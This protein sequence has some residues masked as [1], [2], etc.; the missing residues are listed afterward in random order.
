MHLLL[1]RHGQSTGNAARRIQ[2]WNDEPLTEVG[3]AQALALTRRL[4][5]EQQIDAIY[6][7]P[8]LR[9]CQTAE[10]IADI[11]D[12]AVALDERLKEHHIGVITGLRFE[13]VESQ[14]P[15]I[16]E[17]WQRD[18]W[19]VPIP[20]MEDTDVFQRRVVSAMDE[21]VARHKGDDTI[22]VIAHGG[23]LGAY[24]ASLLALDLRKRQPW[25]FDNA[26]L[27]IV[28]LGGVRPRIALLNDTCHLNHLQ[29]RT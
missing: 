10:I 21:I 26:S 29:R 22:A 11:L 3:R 1:I 20:G 16:V 12:L 9:A 18:V 25:V 6:S 7:S 14:Y 17:R 24:L 5:S 15:E 2:G 28:V 27:S 23:T 8:L 13:E 19:H 4:Q